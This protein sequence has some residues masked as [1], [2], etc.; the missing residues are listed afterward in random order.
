MAEVEIYV[1]QTPKVILDGN[2]MLL[3]YKKAEALLYYMA[4]EKHATRD[5]IATLLWDNCDESTAKKIC[6]TLYIQSGKYLIWT[7]LYL[8]IGR[9]FA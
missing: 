3:P 4:V 2:P 6:V 1:L 8:R 7:Y 5:Q 9:H